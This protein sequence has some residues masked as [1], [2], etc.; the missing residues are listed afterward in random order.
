MFRRSVRHSTLTAVVALAVAGATLQAVPAAAAP[1]AEP[2]VS[3]LVRHDVGKSPQR[4]R[5]VWTPERLRLAAANSQY[6]TPA[7]PP[8]SAPS[9]KAPKPAAAPAVSAAAVP[10]AKYPAAKP[11]AGVSAEATVSVSRRVSNVAAW[12]HSA[13]GRLFY[14]SQDE[15]QWFSCSATAIVSNG[16]N[17]VWT[18]GHCLHQGSGGDAGWRANHIFIPAYGFNSNPYGWWYGVSLLAT[19]GWTDGGDLYDADMGALIVVPET[20]SA[21][22]QDTVGGFGYTFNGGTAY[23]NARSYGYPAVGYNR[24]PSD[25]NDG[26]YMMYCEGNTV[27]AANLNPFDDRLKLQCDMGGGASGGPYVTGIGSSPRIVGANSHRDADANGNY[28]NN[29]L[30][31]SNH[32]GNAA[33]VIDGVNG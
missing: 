11:G 30:Y 6:D 18:A 1:A 33:A 4:L 28:V 29:S 2:A 10:P 17:A 19:N 27:D 25:F 7:L 20:G 15:S 5:A 23:T 16:R 13:I 9:G 31:S 22:L 26:E 24:P 14:S 21:N 3:R 12:P 8:G 32:G